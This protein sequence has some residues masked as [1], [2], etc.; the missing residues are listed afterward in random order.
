M[1]RSCVL[2]V[3]L[4]FFSGCTLSTEP[5][6]FQNESDLDFSD[7]YIKPTF[8]IKPFKTLSE[9]TLNLSHI[10]FSPDGLLLAAGG[11]DGSIVVWSLDTAKKKWFFKNSDRS[12]IS[13]VTSMDFSPDG[14]N[15]VATINFDENIRVWDLTNGKETKILFDGQGCRIAK[16]SLNGKMLAVVTHQ[17]ISVGNRKSSRLMILDA[18]TKKSIHTVPI[19]DRIISALAFHPNERYVILGFDNGM[20]ELLDLKVK[21]TVYSVK[22]HDNY[23]CD[24]NLSNDASMLASSSTDGFVKIWNVSILIESMAKK[25]TLNTPTF[26][27][28]CVRDIGGYV[29]WNSDNNTIGIASLM[30]GDISDSLAN[31]SIWNTLKKKEIVNF[32][33]GPEAF[34]STCVDFSRDGKNVATVHARGR[35]HLWSLK[36]LCN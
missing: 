35:I 28:K 17:L 20:L 26:C 4:L 11:Y 1:K 25:K 6:S 27:I 10:K 31:V 21:K 16:Y 19:N 24:V 36:D 33:N 30:A 29:R 14:K 2:V 18:L 13:Y 9:P 8:Q 15:L 3:C 5:V 34:N 23:I 32:G 22:A 7:L 12:V